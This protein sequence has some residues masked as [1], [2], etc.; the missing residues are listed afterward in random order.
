M[1]TKE[2]LAVFRRLNEDISV[3]SADV[4]ALYP[5]LDI[6]FNIEK[7]CEVFHAN[8]VRVVR[9]NVEELGLYLALNRTEE[10]LRAMELLPVFAHGAGL[11]E[12]GQPPS[13]VVL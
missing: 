12:V 4:K 11:P 3:V 9:L 8:K 5:G 1:G 10:E 13:P 6:D 7:V 2:M